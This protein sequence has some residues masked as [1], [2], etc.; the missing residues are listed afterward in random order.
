MPFRGAGVDPQ[1]AGVVMRTADHAQVQEP[2]NVTVGAKLSGTC[3][4]P[5][6]VGA[7]PGLTDLLE[8]FAALIGEM[9]LVYI[10]HSTLRAVWSGAFLRATASTAL[11]I[12]S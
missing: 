7:L 6:A 11:M 10:Y 8:V 3:D 1:D 4:V 5:E 12:G 2:G 9:G